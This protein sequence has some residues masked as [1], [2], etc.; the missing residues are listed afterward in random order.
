MDPTRGNWKE[1]VLA[2]LQPQLTELW[3]HSTIVPVAPSDPWPTHLGER[4]SPL[5]EWN[6]FFQSQ[7]SIFPIWLHQNS[8][9]EDSKAS[10]HPVLSLMFVGAR[11]WIDFFSEKK[12]LTE[13]ASIYSSTLVCTTTYAHSTMMKERSLMSSKSL[14]RTPHVWNHRFKG[15]SILRQIT[16]IKMMLMTEQ[17]ENHSYLRRQSTLNDSRDIFGLEIDVVV[18]V[19]SARGR[20]GE[21]MWM[22]IGL[23]GGRKGVKLGLVVRRHASPIPPTTWLITVVDMATRC[24]LTHTWKEREREMWQ[25]LDNGK[26]KLTIPSQP[27]QDDYTVVFSIVERKFEL[28]LT[29]TCETNDPKG[30]QLSSRLFPNNKVAGCQNYYGSQKSRQLTLYD[31]ILAPP[32]PQRGGVKLGTLRSTYIYRLVCECEWIMSVM[33]YFYE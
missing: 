17:F 22:V 27:G 26:T 15:A 3:S 19:A 29:L 32:P 13:F 31:F 10:F 6:F 7:F 21:P 28:F 12:T 1:S 23:I 11:F 5:G 25:Q 2:Q 24:W 4:A 20:I 33:N 9:F 30:I 14:T 18:A 8:H 16:D